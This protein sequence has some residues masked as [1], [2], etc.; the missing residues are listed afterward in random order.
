MKIDK[1]N[2][3]KIKMWQKTMLFFAAFFSLSV[4]ISSCKKKENP[5]GKDV[6]PPGSLMSSA[7][8]DTFQIFSYTVIE[9]SLNTMDPEFNLVGSYH[10][11]VFGEV[12]AS[13]YTQLTLSGFSP[14]FGDLSTLEVDSAVFAFE[15]GGY[16][17]VLNEQ[18]FE[19]YEIMEDLTRDS[20]YTNN[21]VVTVGS[22]NLVPT[23]NNQG[24]ITPNTEMLT[25]V[26]NDTLNPQLRI[27]IKKDFAKHLLTLAESATS[28]ATFLEDFK[29]LHVKVNNPTNFPGEGAILYLATSRAASKLTVYYTSEGEQNKFDFI[30]T[31]SAVDFNKLEVDY[32]GTKVQQVID[33]PELGDEEFYAQAFVARAKMEF[34][35]INDLP[36]N[37]IVHS[38][39]LEIPVSFYQG[40]PFYISSEV[41]VGAKLFEGDER[42]YTLSS[43]AFNS[44]RKAYVVDLRTYIQNI[45]KGE[46]QNNGIYVSPRR[47][48]TSAERI[49]FNGANSTNKKQPKLNIV[50]TEL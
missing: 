39:T 4:A 27:P 23:D 7:G 34:S 13:F 20:T 1:N 49:I 45:I 15:Y 6:L 16:Y 30:V 21:S 50:Y 19:V 2:T 37:I 29:G 14:E 35:S 5:F 33:Q 42:I 12:E 47:F 40:D 17:G 11:E 28:D 3:F 26:G 43:V 18:L 24:L 48:N 22:E 46:I 38:A 41:S 9:D 8:V 31:N 25:V 36:E 32:S 10:D 44:F